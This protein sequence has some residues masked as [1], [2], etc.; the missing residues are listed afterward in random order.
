VPSAEHVALARMDVE[1]ALSGKLGKLGVPPDVARVVLNYLVLGYDV[2]AIV[3]LISSETATY[4]LK[5]VRGVR[6]AYRAYIKEQQREGGR[7]A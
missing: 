5:A 4:T 7:H 3:E 1:V 2:A 6:T